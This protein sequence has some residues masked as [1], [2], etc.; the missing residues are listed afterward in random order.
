LLVNH[1]VGVENEVGLGRDGL[2]WVG[3]QGGKK[4]FLVDF[5]VWWSA[6][7]TMAAGT[8]TITKFLE[9][10]RHLSRQLANSAKVVHIAH[11]SVAYQQGNPDGSLCHG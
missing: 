9:Y 7:L 11:R 10:C 8:L 4:P 6:P 5:E 2:V 3:R 1:I